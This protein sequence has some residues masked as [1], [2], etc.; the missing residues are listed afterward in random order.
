MESMGPEVVLAAVPLNITGYKYDP[1][2]EDALLSLC[3]D[4][5]LLTLCLFAT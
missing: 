5:F 3:S 1:R 2:D 4:F